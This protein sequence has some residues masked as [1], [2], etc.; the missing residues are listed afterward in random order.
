[1]GLETLLLGLPALISGVHFGLS[2]GLTQE[3]NSLRRELISDQA[4]QR[5]V[6]RSVLSIYI[7]MAVS[8]ATA[9]Q[10]ILNFIMFSMIS[11]LPSEVFSRWFIFLIGILSWMKINSE[12]LGDLEAMPRRCEDNFGGVE[13][14]DSQSN[15]LFSVSVTVTALSIFQAVAYLFFFL[16]SSKN[17]SFFVWNSLSLFS[18]W[19]LSFWARPISQLTKLNLVLR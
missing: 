4:I 11:I 17:E 18:I 1:M 2:L 16:L 15:A 14:T 8:N 9:M 6:A 10:L 5:V 3:L 13:F 19:F 12:L 7:F